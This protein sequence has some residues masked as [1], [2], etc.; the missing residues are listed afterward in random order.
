MAEEDIKQLSILEK[1]KEA[2][3]SNNFLQQVL[4]K[5]NILIL[6]S[7]VFLAFVFV[8]ISIFTDS[9]DQNFQ[10]NQDSLKAESKGLTY[11]APSNSEVVKKKRSKKNKK[12]KY[13]IMFRG[14]DND[15][16]NQAVR[17]LSINTIEFEINQSGSK[18][19]L[20]VDQEMFNDAKN[21]LAIK[22]IPSATK[23]GFAIFDEASNLGATEFDKRIRLMRA[24]SG[25]MELAISQF[26]AIDDAQVKL[27][28]PEQRLFDTEETPVTASILIRPSKDH[29]LSDTII[30]AIISL[31]SNGI[32]NLDEKNISVVDTY[33]RVL[34]EGIFER[35]QKLDYLKKGVLPKTDKKDERLTETSPKINFNDWLSIKNDYESLYKKQSI[36]SLSDQLPEDSYFLGVQVFFDEV[37]NKIPKIN[38]IEVK[39]EVNKNYPDLNFN[40]KVK[41]EIFRNIS[42]AIPYVKGRDQIILTLEE[43]PIPDSLKNIEPE[44]EEDIVP[45]PVEKEVLNISKKDKSALNSLFKYWP[46]FLS[47]LLFTTI[48]YLIFFSIKTF[49]FK[50]EDLD[51]STDL[52]LESL[53]SNKEETIVPT[54]SIETKIE[55]N[56]GIPKSLWTPKTVSLVDQLNRDL[57]DNPEKLVKLIE[58]LFEKEVVNG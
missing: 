50:K 40:T 8:L 49:F 45:D 5:R 30:Y 53:E 6:S 38:K 36:A 57:K 39:V 2:I 48:L 18:Y 28:M 46:I 14:L 32:E 1:I 11:T 4:T 27:V 51:L 47:G 23:K 41:Q 29:V 42:N 20:S 19:D 26:E 35:I 21:L 13:K 12:I 37:V 33:G 25:E 3:D 10:N 43:L 56:S 24:L 7:V 17:E 31:V 34:S 9:S 54:R 16:L 15:Q 58:E 22:G 52:S 55:Q 44:I